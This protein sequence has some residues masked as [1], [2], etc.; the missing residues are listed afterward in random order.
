MSQQVG[1][2]LFLIT[3]IRSSS[4]L[5]AVLVSTLTEKA[6]YLMPVRVKTEAATV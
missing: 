6:P 1:M 3:L 2:A 5:L 4:K